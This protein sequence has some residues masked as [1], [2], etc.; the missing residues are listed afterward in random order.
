MFRHCRV[1]STRPF[2]KLLFAQLAVFVLIEGVEHSAGIGHSRRT[3][4]ARGRGALALRLG[5]VTVMTA[6]TTVMSPGLWSMPVMPVMMARPLGLLFIASAAFPF[7]R[8]V[9]Q[10]DLRQCDDRQGRQ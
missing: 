6:G 2:H 9:G 1:D 5:G 3:A 4:G 7:L 10:H 8:A